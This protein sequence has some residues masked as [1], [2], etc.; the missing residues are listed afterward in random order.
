MS[1]HGYLVK[2]LTSVPCF[3]ICHDRDKGTMVKHDLA[4][5]TMVMARVPW[6]RTLGYLFCSIA[7]IATRRA[8]IDLIAAELLECRSEFL[9]I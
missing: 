3:M 5:F 2:I 4:R 1:Y 7:F 6:L 8:K 9:K